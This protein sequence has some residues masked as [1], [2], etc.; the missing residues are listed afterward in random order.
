MQEPCIVVLSPKYVSVYV[1]YQHFVFS[2]TGTKL[3]TV[4]VFVTVTPWM[5]RHLHAL[6]ICDRCRGELVVEIGKSR[7][8][9]RPASAVVVAAED[10]TPLSHGAD[11]VTVT[12]KSLYIVKNLVQL[13][14]IYN[15]V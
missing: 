11:E 7:P 6:E 8:P 14:A 12:N 1:L 9:L 4:A 10:S 15:R 13:L 3:V 5:F 2:P